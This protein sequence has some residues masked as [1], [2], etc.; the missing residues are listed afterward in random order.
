[1]PGNANNQFGA[2]FK[3]DYTLSDMTWFSASTPRYFQ[4]ATDST[5]QQIFIS[6]DNVA[7]SPSLLAYMYATQREELKGED[8]RLVTI[9]STH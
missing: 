7:K 1:M 2:D 8:I 4:P 9:G 5:G 6:G 3:H